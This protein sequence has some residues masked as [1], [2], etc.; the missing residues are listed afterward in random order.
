[1]I[2]YEPNEALERSKLPQNVIDRGVK[3]PGLEASTGADLLV[4]PE[5]SNYERAIIMQSRGSNLMDISKQLDIKLPDLI[6]LINDP[7]GYAI[8]Q[9]LFAGAI[10]VQRK[11]GDDFVQSMGARLNDSIAKMCE[12][13]HKQYQRVILVTGVFSKKDDTLILDGK[14]T[15]WKYSSFQGAVSS[16]KYKGAC[17]EFVPTDADILDWIRVQEKQ[18]LSYKHNDVNGL[19]LPYIIRL[20]YHH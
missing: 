4:V 6:N 10:L 14:I 3:M 2:Y 17:V 16:I 8:P 19:C 11:S 12:V 18:L 9:W 5:D 15:N 7:L 1:M 20:I 13:S